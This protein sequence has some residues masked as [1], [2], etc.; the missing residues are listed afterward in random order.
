MSRQDTHI[1][2]QNKGVAMASTTLPAIRR[3]FRACS[4][5]VV[6][7]CALRL[8][9]AEVDLT[10]EPSCP[11]A[12]FAATE[13]QQA[14]AVRGLDAAISEGGQTGAVKTILLAVASP[15]DP[16]VGELQPEGFAIRVARDAARETYTIV[17][18]DPG[19][20]LYGGLELAEQIRIG[21]LDGVTP[22]IYNPPMALRG[23]KFNLPLDARTPSYSDVCDSAQHNIPVVWEFG[24]W[25]AYLDS[26][27]RHRFN[28]VTLWSLHPFPSMVRVPEYPDVA[29]SDVTRSTVAWQEHYDL[30]GRGFDAPEILGNLET[31]KRMTIDQKIEHWRKVMRYAKDRG[32]DA[33]RTLRTYHGPRISRPANPART[34]PP[35]HRKPGTARR[36]DRHRG[37]GLPGPLLRRQDSRGDVPGPVPEDERIG[38]LV[39]GGGRSAARS[40]VVDALR[41][42]GQGSV[43]QSPL[44]KPRRL[45]RLGCT[46]QGGAGGHRDR[47]TNELMGQTG[48]ANRHRE[49]TAEPALEAARQLLQGIPKLRLLECRKGSFHDAMQAKLRQLVRRRNNEVISLDFDAI[50]ARFLEVPAPG[51]V[52]DGKPLSRVERVSESR[53]SQ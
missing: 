4:A 37:H 29:L 44:D 26:L 48:V 34:A 47:P 42:P 32:H 15:D 22:T 9:A 10:V 27:A 36:V 49:D 33:D 6:V 40:A 3:W 16:D 52:P 39:A 17:G 45:C 50:A 12:M 28:T 24:F 41:C 5:V 38:R 8:C 30:Q 18:S 19:G 23:T 46:D 25:K 21:G 2:P 7:L 20:L 13:I 11:Q 43:H 1:L 53:D 14:L 51:C 31:V 35:R